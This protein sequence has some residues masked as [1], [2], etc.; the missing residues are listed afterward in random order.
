MSEG[1]I[2]FVLF[3]K[4]LAFQKFTLVLFRISNSWS[5]QTILLE[6][7]GLHC[8]LFVKVHFCF[9][10][11]RNSDIVSCG[12]ALVKTFFPFFLYKR[13][14][15]YNSIYRLQ[16]QQ[17]FKV[18]SCY[19]L[20]GQNNVDFDCLQ[21]TVDRLKGLLYSMQPPKLIYSGCSNR[22]NSIAFT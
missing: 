6:F 20:Y 3:Q 11:R 9:V 21:P 10:I 15:F 5:N 18:F 7:S 22:Y 8:C 19:N 14:G 4:T 2:W 1:S 16:I 17:L 13:V 12:C